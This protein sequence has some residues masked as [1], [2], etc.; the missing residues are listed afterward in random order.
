MAPKT[1]VDRAPSFGQDAGAISSHETR[2]KVSVKK[3]RPHPGPLPRGEGEVV[4]AS[5][6]DDGARSVQGFTVHDLSG[7]SYPGGQGL[8]DKIVQGIGN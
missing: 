4:S 2:G 8:F 5:W 1:R 3:A 6:Q 7:N